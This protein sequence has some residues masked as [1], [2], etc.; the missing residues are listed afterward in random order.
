MHRTPDRFGHLSSTM[1][2]APTTRHCSGAQR[3]SRRPPPDP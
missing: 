2:G 1:V 3:A